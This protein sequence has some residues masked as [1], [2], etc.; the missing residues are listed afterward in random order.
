MKMTEFW[1]DWEVYTKLYS[2]N[3]GPSLFIKSVKAEKFSAQAPNF[4]I[5]QK[6]AYRTKIFG[7]RWVII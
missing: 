1:R 3:K 7:P 5:F 2:I 4:L 6:L